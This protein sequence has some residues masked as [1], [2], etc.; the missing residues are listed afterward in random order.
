L[1]ALCFPAF[2]GNLHSDIAIVRA[3]LDSNNVS[4]SLSSV[5]TTK[6]GRIVA[7]H[8]NETYRQPQQRNPGFRCG[9]RVSKIPAIINRMD[10][11]D[12][13]EI[14][15]VITGAKLT[16]PAS[17]GGLSGLRS[18]A[19]RGAALD[20]V[21][22]CFS[23][24]I[25]L[26]ALKL[27]GDDLVAFPEV[28]TSLPDLAEVDLSDNR[29][30]SIPKSIGSMQHLR[31]FAIRNQET[32]TVF[33]IP[34]ELARDS[35][36]SVLDISFNN[37]D[38]FP[39]SVLHFNHLSELHLENCRLSALPPE[40]GTM[41]E[42]TYFNASWNGLTG[43]PANLS[44]LRSLKT[45]ILVSNP[46]DSFPSVICELR[47]LS[48]LNLQD[49]HLISLPS[50]IGTLS[51]LQELNVCYN[52]LSQLPAEIGNLKNVTTLR[53]HNNKLSSL[54]ED[55]TKLTPQNWLSLK[56]NP[57]YN[58]SRVDSRISAWLCQY[59]VNWKTDFPACSGQ[60]SILTKGP[61]RKNQPVFTV[62]GQTAHYDLSSSAQVSLKL[63]DMQGR[64]LKVLCEGNQTGGTYNVPIPAA[65]TTQMCALALRV[66][67]VETIRV[68][69]NV[70]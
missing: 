42:L 56:N 35:L 2:A 34:P 15:Y 19:I 22:N 70:R 36:L 29:I 9:A 57:L 10:A 16:L 45:L 50:T 33:S 17:F 66:D 26:Q 4:V 47:S 1:I 27:A 58:P 30:H 48:C 28:I 59:D 53:L 51:S 49:C 64:L 32:D 13:L 46:L 44:C 23:E 43:L 18:L 65:F 63:F 21:P 31:S 39:S 61:A 5:A 11:L 41:R 67:G 37:L 7:L 12:T 6:N 62:G 69:S 20:T 8:F 25:G 40:L 14:S 68:L 60:T 55:I 38:I 3:I 24:L 52:Q 54:P